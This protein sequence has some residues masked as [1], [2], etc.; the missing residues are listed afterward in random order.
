MIGVAD[1]DFTLIARCQSNDLAAF[2]EIVARYQ[3]RVYNYVCRMVGPIPDAED[4]AQEVFVRAYAS[5]GS[6]KS[7]ATLNTWL[8]RIATNL[9]ID[10]IRRSRKLQN[11]TSSLSREADDEGSVVLDVPDSRFDPEAVAMNAEL[12]GQL[13]AALASLSDRLRAVFVLHDIEGLQ[14]DEIATVAGCPIGTVKSRLFSARMALRE[15]LLPY[16]N[17]VPVPDAARRRP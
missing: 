9:C 7:R 14:Y 15:R 12:G 10:Y 2:D 11:V 4:L 8:Y 13:D 6:F 1:A 3:H 5:I 16:L 17:G